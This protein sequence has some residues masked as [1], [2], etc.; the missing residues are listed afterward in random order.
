MSADQST[1]DRFV[2]PVEP[3]F[4][5]LP[6]TAVNHMRKY[7]PLKKREQKQQRAIENAFRLPIKQ[8]TGFAEFVNKL[9]GALQT[10]VTGI[11]LEIQETEFHWNRR[12]GDEVSFFKDETNLEFSIGV[13]DVKRGYKTEDMAYSIWFTIEPALPPYDV[14]RVPTLTWEYF[15]TD[16]NRIQPFIPQLQK[17]FQPITNDEVI[18]KGLQFRIRH[19]EKLTKNNFLSALEKFPTFFMYLKDINPNPRELKKFVYPSTMLEVYPVI[20]IHY[21]EKH[22]LL[23]HLKQMQRRQR[24]VY[25]NLLDRDPLDVDPDKDATDADRKR[26]MDEF[27]KERKRRY[28]IGGELSESIQPF[29]KHQRT[30]A[31]RLL[32]RHQGDV[33]AAAHMLAKMKF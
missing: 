24:D 23:P 25:E 12:R 13:F 2:E 10:A 3:D 32:Q 22:K 7:D 1:L 20:K 14:S 16:F 33:E 21:P 15:E 19:S 31:A 17:E 8:D 30:A 26:E 6:T 5:S 18:P 4:S 11:S 9:E 28:G 29:L 27:V